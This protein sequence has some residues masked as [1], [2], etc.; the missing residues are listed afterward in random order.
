[1]SRQAGRTEAVVERTSLRRLQVHSTNRVD[2]QND[3]GSRLSGILFF[4]Y[5]NLAERK[6]TP[7][8]VVIIC[9]AIAAICPRTWATDWPTIQ[10]KNTNSIVYLEIT[11]IKDPPGKPEVRR[12]PWTATGF[13]VT[14]DG[15]VLTTSHVFPDSYD[16]FQIL[17]R[18]GSRFAGNSI[19]LTEVGAGEQYGLEVLHFRD[20]SPKT[21]VVLQDSI[22]ISA[23]SSILV[24][25]FPGNQDLF[26][27]TGVIG[28]INGD[29]GWWQTATA[30]NPGNSGS[31]VF[32]A[33]GNVV[34]IVVG[35]V[36]GVSSSNFLIQLV[37]PS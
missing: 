11:G 7:G 23:S 4:V 1:L 35:D 19:Q 30:V 3:A 24:L 36:P 21:P 33:L 10:P 34:A 20:N 25:G 37:G 26:G 16:R 31:P 17:G 9:L 12:G 2:L 32:D 8:C 14:K 22:T 18:V 15:A 29:N 28:S 5:V 6:N 13:V 27:S